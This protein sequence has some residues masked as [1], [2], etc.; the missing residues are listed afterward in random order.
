MLEKDEMPTYLAGW[1]AQV[2]KRKSDPDGGEEVINVSFDKCTITADKRCIIAG[3][4]LNGCDWELKITRSTRKS[5]RWRGEAFGNEK[6]DYP[7]D[8]WLLV[9]ESSG[10]AAFKLYGKCE[11]RLTVQNP[12]IEGHIDLV[13]WPARMSNPFDKPKRRAKKSKPRTPKKSTSKAKSKSSKKRAPARSG[14]A[15]SKPKKSSVKRPASK[16]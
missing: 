16:K 3:F 1:C 6:Y 10:S 4:K 5:K 8:L 9:D 11:Q 13:V 7:L 2:W 15:R 14:Q 12:D